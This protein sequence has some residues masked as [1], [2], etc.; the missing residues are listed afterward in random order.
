ME[1]GLNQRLLAH[2]NVLGGIRRRISLRG[3]GIVE[4]GK[5]VQVIEIKFP[6]HKM[7]ERTNP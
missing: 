6:T 3:P 1:G 5:I 2:R 4:N 7:W